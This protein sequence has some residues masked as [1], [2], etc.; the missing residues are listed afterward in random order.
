MGS[1]GGAGEAGWV[2][3]FRSGEKAGR[4]LRGG[5][6]AQHRLGTALR[7]PDSSCGAPNSGSQGRPWGYSCLTPRTWGR[8]ASSQQ[9]WDWNAS[10]HGLS[11]SGAPTGRFASRQLILVPS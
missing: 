7:S 10:P 8:S 6:G 1:A 2:V 5:M 3:C 4:P 11:D 9:R